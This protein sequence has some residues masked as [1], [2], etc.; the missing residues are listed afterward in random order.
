M[1]LAGDRRRGIGYNEYML[2][3]VLSLLAGAQRLV[4]IVDSDVTA[5]QVAGA[6]LASAAGWPSMSVASLLA[7]RL[8][9]VPPAGRSRLVR[10]V[11]V[12][13][14][15]SV[16]GASHSPVLLGDLA[17][18]FDPSLEADV[19]QLLELCAREAC[20]VAL[21]PGTLTATTLCFAEPRHRHYRCWPR[22]ATGTITLR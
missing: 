6:G 8:R 14:I 1:G 11:L 15:H 21:W 16:C 13:A 20:L 17:L 10:P 3:Q 22:P 2:V 5:L 19:L 18:L 12:E 7:E 9:P 4:L